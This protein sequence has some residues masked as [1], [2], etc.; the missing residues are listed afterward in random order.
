MF[1]VLME[2]Q[3][4]DGRREEKSKTKNQDTEWKPLFYK[5]KGSVQTNVCTILEI[6][7]QLKTTKYNI[8]P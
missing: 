5:A 6:S 8:L 4:A 1:L 2:C 3:A 7:M